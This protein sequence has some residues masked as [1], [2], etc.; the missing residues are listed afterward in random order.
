MILSLYSDLATFRPVL[1]SNSSLCRRSIW[2]ALLLGQIASLLICVTAA[3]CHLLNK[4]YD[5]KLPAGEY[6]DTLIKY[7]HKLPAGEYSDTIKY[8]LK[9]PAGKNLG[10]RKI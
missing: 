10:M 8:D 2:R 1:S 5:L 4:K 7:D 6:S 3:C 9:L